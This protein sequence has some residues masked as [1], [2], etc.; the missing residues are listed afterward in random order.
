MD[1]LFLT[2]SKEY[3]CKILKYLANHHNVV[4]IVCKEKKFLNGTTLEE[5][6]LEHN[7]NIFDNNEVYQM[8]ASGDMPHIDLA[9][10]NTYGRLIKSPLIQW[11]SGNCINFHAAILPDYKGLYTYNHGLFNGEKEWGVSVHYINEKFDEGKIIQ[12]KKFSINPDK[13]TVKELERKTQ[14]IAYELTIEIVE[15]W[16]KEGPLPSRAQEGKGIYYSK[17]DFE[18]AKKVKITDGAD[19]VKKKIHAFWC[20]PYEGAYIEIGGEHF[21]LLPERKDILSE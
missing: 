18:K 19:L 7:I 4:G 10:S 6:C 20:P 16:E 9:I 12:I 15:K 13:I 2:K 5:I 11:A 21:Q 17:E 14:K 3:T 8:I 1:I